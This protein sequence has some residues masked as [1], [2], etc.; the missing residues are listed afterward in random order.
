MEIHQAKLQYLV[1]EM[2]KSTGLE[3]NCLAPPFTNNMTMGKLFNLSKLRL[4]YK[5][6]KI[7]VLTS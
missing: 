2:V 4:L 6:D 3:S 7:I 5:M 1:G